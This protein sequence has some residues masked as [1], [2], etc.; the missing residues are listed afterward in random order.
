MPHI[1]LQEDLPG[2][3]GLVAYRPD[4]G[5]ALYEL[6]EALLRS[7]STLSQAERELIAAYV[8]SRNEC[9]FCASSHAA[10]SR[11]LYGERAALVDAVIEDL[12]SAPV[13]A[14]LRA[15]LVIA[16]KVQENGRL[17][18]P[19]DV[20]AA[21]AEGAT[22]REIHD[23]VLIAAAFSMFNRYVDGLATWAPE[24]PEAYAEMGRRM[25]EQGYAGRFRQVAHAK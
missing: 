4:T 16:A 14:K 19:E 8:S 25:A 12:E 18:T 21:R 10:A 20:A 24:E 7:E 23:A 1:P 17:V 15:L 22:D 9:R 6:A 5:R 13:D 2:I 3:R 11:H